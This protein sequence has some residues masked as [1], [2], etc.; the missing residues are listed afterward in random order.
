MVNNAF[1][2]AEGSQQAVNNPANVISL[3]QENVEQL[4]QLLQKGLTHV[5]FSRRLLW[6]YV[7]FR[8]IDLIINSNIYICYHKKKK[9]SW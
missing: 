8:C 5:A 6:S 4:L 3:S 1:N 9:L 2:A 7:L